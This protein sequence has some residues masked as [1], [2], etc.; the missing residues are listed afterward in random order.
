MSQD[1]ILNTIRGKLE[2]QISNGTPCVMHALVKQ[3]SATIEDV[4]YANRLYKASG[5]VFNMQKAYLPV[6]KID[7][8]Y[9]G[10]EIT[11]T[12]SVNELAVAAGVVYNAGVAITVNAD[13]STV[14]TRPATG[15][16]AWYVIVASNAGAVSATKGTDGDSLLATFGSS[17]GQKPY[18]GVTDTILGYVWLYSDT[19]AVIDASAILGGE[20]ANISYSLSPL[21]GGVLL[22][23]AVPLSHTGAVG[24]GV[25]ASFYDL[26]AEGVLS[27]APA[28]EEAEITQTL[29]ANIAKR[30]SSS[31]YPNRMNNQ[32]KDWKLTA[33]KG[34]TSQFWVDN[35]L[36][37]TQ[38]VLI[39]LYEDTSD[40]HYYLGFC[41]RSGDGF[42]ANTKAGYRDDA[43][44][45][46]AVGELRRVVA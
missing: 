39:R 31:C 12:A 30:T 24:R 44:N 4:V 2:T 45:F 20:S 38:P 28:L 9:S 42:K 43:L 22:D 29:G 8:V 16:Y 1:V 37:S 15:K 17:A 32:E 11:P 25:Y 5:K 33:K 26:M 41:V 3:A 13:T 18:A 27:S 7:G 40:T 35:A 10:C 46:E 19:A 34:R 36:S 14:L 21:D 23:A 6:V